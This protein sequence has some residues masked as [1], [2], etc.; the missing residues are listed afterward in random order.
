MNHKSSRKIV[1]FNE[2]HG[3]FIYTINK[4][5]YRYVGTS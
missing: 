5:L 2:K 1:K 4:H 3:G